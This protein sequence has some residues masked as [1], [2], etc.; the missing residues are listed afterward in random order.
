MLVEAFMQELLIHC[1]VARA[2]EWESD[3]LG[4]DYY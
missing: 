1:G 4:G 2:N 3:E